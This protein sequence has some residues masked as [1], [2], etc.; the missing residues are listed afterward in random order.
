MQARPGVDVPYSS[1]HRF[2]VAHC[3][4]AARRGPTVRW[5]ETRPGELA[6]VDFGRLGLGWDPGAEQMRV[7]HALVVALVHSRHPSSPQF[8][9][10]WDIPRGD[11]R[12]PTMETGV[13]TRR[14]AFVEEPPPL[15]REFLKSELPPLDHFSS[16]LAR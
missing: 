2:A 15:R 6:E 11:L 5:A 4:F 9:S 10:F 8:S 3:G 7:H 1:L 13:G 14:V 12:N 16:R